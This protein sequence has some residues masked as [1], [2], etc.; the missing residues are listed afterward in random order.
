MAAVS[1]GDILLVVVVCGG[2]GRH[3]TVLG[4][5]GRHGTYCDKASLATCRMVQWAK[6][7]LYTYLKSSML[8]D[9]WAM[10]SRLSWHDR[11]RRAHTM[12]EADA[13]ELIRK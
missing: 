10:S 13:N 11:G 8:R 7:K 6:L 4:I 2:F 9:H 5:V 3:V 12:F 1:R